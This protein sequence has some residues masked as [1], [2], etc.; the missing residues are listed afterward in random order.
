MIFKTDSNII[1]FLHAFING[2]HHFALDGI[3][4]NKCQLV[5]NLHTLKRK[6]NTSIDAVSLL[7]HPQHSHF[8]LVCLQSVASL[9]LKNSSM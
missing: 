3:V 8:P 4:N 7:L 1:L 2:V 9:D 5:E 6:D